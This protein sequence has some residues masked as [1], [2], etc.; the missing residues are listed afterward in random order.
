MSFA[1]TYDSPF[2]RIIAT[3]ADGVGLSSL[4]FALNQEPSESD[5]PVFQL[6]FRFLDS[7]FAGV[8][9]EKRPPISVQATDFQKKVWQELCK[10]PAGSTI[11][12]G[13]LGRRVGCASAQAV[14]NAVA[15]NPVLI[16]IPCHRVVRCDGIGNYSA[17]CYLKAA[18]LNHEGALLP[19]LFS[20]V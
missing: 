8:Y 20:V 10:V 18:L 11:T 17:G 7:F 4:R 19:S 2:G 13:E 9:T 16:L 12:Y 3:S 6:T 5:L 15:G 14:G 1:A